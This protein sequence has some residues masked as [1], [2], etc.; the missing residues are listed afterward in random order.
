MVHTNNAHTED[1][2]KSSLVRAACDAHRN[3]S[4]AGPDGCA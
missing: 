4:A 1:M 2:L 3:I